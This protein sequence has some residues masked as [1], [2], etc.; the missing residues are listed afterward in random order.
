MSRHPREP[1]NLD[2]SLGNE[3]DGFFIERLKSSLLIGLQCQPPQAE[4]AN[5]RKAPG[6]GGLKHTLIHARLGLELDLQDN[7]SPFVNFRGR[8]C[9]KEYSIDS[10][11]SLNQKRHLGVSGS[12]SPVWLLSLELFSN[13]SNT[14][15][16][17]LRVCS[18]TGGYLASFEKNVS[19]VYSNA[20]V[21]FPATSLA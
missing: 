16:S 19:K 4:I 8:H 7:Y 12:S 9:A 10:S 6:A 13:L 21:F 1:P 15:D 3:S 5:L 11:E 14:A 17:L 18:D 20:D 2:S